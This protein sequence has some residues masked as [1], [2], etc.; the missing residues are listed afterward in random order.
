MGHVAVVRRGGGTE[1]R[2]CT[3][4]QKMAAGAI[5]STDKSVWTVAG[6]VATDEGRGGKCGR[7]HEK[8]VGITASVDK[9]AW[10]AGGYAGG[11]RAAANESTGPPLEGTSSPWTRPRRRLWAMLSRTWRRHGGGH[12]TAA[13]DFASAD[14]SARTAVRDDLSDET[15]RGSGNGGCSF[16]RGHRGRR[17][18]SKQGCA[19]FRGACRHGSQR[20]ERR[21]AT[22]RCRC[23]HEKAVGITASADKS[24]WNAVGDASL[25][26]AAR[27]R[28]IGGP[29]RRTRPRYG[30]GVTSPSWM[31]PRG[32]P[33]GVMSR[34]RPWR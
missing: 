33:C 32:R 25:N 4:G 1:T 2:P 14:K 19:N 12:G 27:G 20:G 9:F 21:S 29:P 24:A 18:L 11:R 16:G 26:E 10:N 6:D 22:S 23:G 8:A 17:C 3:C 13:G 31:R 28:R 5:A 34:T 7:G 30:C 15:V